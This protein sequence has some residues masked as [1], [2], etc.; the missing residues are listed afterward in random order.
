MPKDNDKAKL[1]GDKRREGQVRMTDLG[2]AGSTS[3]TSKESSGR[4]GSDS[5]SGAA[6]RSGGKA[7]AGKTTAGSGG[8]Q[9]ANA[10]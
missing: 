6:P 9:K 5:K 2:K 4:N 7:D 10:R 1:A 8:K 3:G